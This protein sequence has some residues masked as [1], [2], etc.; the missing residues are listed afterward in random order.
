MTGIRILAEA[1][2]VK[3]RGR[4]AYRLNGDWTMQQQ[5]QGQS[6]STVN[7]SSRGPDNEVVRQQ[8]EELPQSE[9]GEISRSFEGSRTKKGMR[10]GDVRVKLEKSRQSARE[11][12]A[13]KKMRY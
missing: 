4:E 10:N 13:R 5:P 9:G 1:V 3:G 11:C 8:G 7:P 6:Q 2:L 12:R